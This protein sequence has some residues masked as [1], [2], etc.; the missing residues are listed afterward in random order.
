MAAG[1]A[2]E[3]SRWSV[4][5]R[6]QEFKAPASAYVE[7]C[8][9]RPPRCQQA[10]LSRKGSRVLHSAGQKSSTSC[11]MLRLHCQTQLPAGGQLSERTGSAPAPAPGV[12]LPAPPSCAIHDH[13]HCLK[14]GAV[15]QQDKT[16]LRY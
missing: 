8:I 14:H 1:E 4:S 16:H 5:T 7:S 2:P 13:L 12:W 15:N 6:P 10:W 3:H 9:C 11:S